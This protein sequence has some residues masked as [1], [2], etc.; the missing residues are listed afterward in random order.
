MVSITLILTGLIIAG[1]FLSGGGKFIS[2]A[3]AS[4]KLAAEQS[5]SFLDSTIADIKMKTS[6]EMVA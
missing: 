5:K 2:P 1:F 3:I 4:S 6:G